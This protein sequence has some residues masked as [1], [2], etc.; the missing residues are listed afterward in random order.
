M[1]IYIYIYILHA[2][3]SIHQA[4]CLVLMYMYMCI[5]VCTLTQ[6]DPA[7]V[8]RCRLDAL[9]TSRHTMIIS[10]THIY[11]NAYAQPAIMDGEFL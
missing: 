2:Y 9:Q 5:Y 7:I 1:C 11:T 3:I 8:D 6:R 4:C 10:S